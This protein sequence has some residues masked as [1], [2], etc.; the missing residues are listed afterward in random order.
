SLIH[1]RPES[2]V[3]FQQGSAANRRTP[4]SHFGVWIQWVKG[5][6]QRYPQE[7]RDLF[8]DSAAQRPLRYPVASPRSHPVGIRSSCAASAPPPRLPSP[9]DREAWSPFA[10]ARLLAVR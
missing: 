8:R 6:L 5:P 2:P 10:P 7:R 4:S 1:S 3:H 9:T